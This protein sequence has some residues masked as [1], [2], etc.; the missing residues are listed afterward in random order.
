MTHTLDRSERC[1]YVR[2]CPGYEG[3]GRAKMWRTPGGWEAL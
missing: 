1:S 2:R 3:A